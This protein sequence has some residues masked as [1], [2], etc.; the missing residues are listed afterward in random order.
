MFDSEYLSLHERLRDV[1]IKLSE[2]LNESEIEDLQYEKQALEFRIEC[3][4]EDALELLTAQ[5]E[6]K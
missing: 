4:Y 2:S 5:E 3:M 1:E 6:N